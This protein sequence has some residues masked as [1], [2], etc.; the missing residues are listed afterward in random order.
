[1]AHPKSNKSVQST[2]KSPRTLSVLAQPT[3]VLQGQR[4]M[5]VAVTSVPQKPLI[6]D[7]EVARASRMPSTQMVPTFVE[8]SKGSFVDLEPVQRKRQLRA[9]A[10]RLAEKRVLKARAD[11]RAAEERVR[12]LTDLD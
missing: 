3:P 12:V 11:L 10:L 9:R 8:L 4:E 6:V 7:V 2:S 1:M 5:R